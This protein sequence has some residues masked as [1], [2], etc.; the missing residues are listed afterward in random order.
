MTPETVGSRVVCLAGQG[1]ED[2][3]VDDGVLALDVQ[4]LSFEMDG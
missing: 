4:S 3:G 2:V 1:V